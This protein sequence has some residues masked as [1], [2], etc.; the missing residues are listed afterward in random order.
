MNSGDNQSKF[1]TIKYIIFYMMTKKRMQQSF[2]KLSLQLIR[3]MIYGQYEIEIKS[4]H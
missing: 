3:T 1:I 2:D 4:V